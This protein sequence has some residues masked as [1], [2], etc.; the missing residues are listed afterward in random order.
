MEVFIAFDGNLEAVQ[1]LE[2]ALYGWE[3]IRFAEVNCLELKP[4][5]KF[6]IQRRVLADNL[7][8]GD[9]YVLA[10]IDAKPEEPWV[11]SQI[12][13]LVPTRKQ[14]GLAL[15]RPSFDIG[16]KVRVIRKGIIH[17]W[18]AQET[19]NYEL[20]HG[21]AIVQAGYTMETWD[22]IWYRHLPK[23]NPLLIN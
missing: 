15:I 2:Q 10:D 3:K 4:G 21:L 14:C 19:D 23:A 16:G 1:F 20:E 5:Q 11:I 22:D 17:K 7:A 8:K 6:E 13:K 12:Q 18:P 9:W